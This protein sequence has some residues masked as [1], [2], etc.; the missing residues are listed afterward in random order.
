MKLSTRFL[1]YMKMLR[2]MTGNKVIFRAGSYADLTTVFEGNNILSRSSSLHHS[3]IQRYSY[4]GDHSKFTNTSIG[5]YTCIG[6]NVSNIVGEHPTKS[7]VSIHPVFFS[8]LRQ[9][10]FTYVENQKFKE[11]YYADE[12][13]Q[14]INIIGNDVWIGRRYPSST[15]SRLETGRSS[16]PAPS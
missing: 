9:I 15:A 5:R 6:P 10:G 12:K 2:E 11:I 13:K 16:P 1:S 4:V 7:F 8:M 3:R 14:W